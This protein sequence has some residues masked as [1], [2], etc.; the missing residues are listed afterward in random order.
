MTAQVEAPPDAASTGELA[1]TA[2]ATATSIRGSSVMLVGRVAAMG[3]NFAAQ[4]LVVRHLSKA[5][6]GAFAWAL[7]SV[8]LLQSVIALGIDRADTRF[9]AH[10]DERDQ[11]ARLRGLLVIE[12]ST[13]VMIGLAALGAA[14]T[15]QAHLTG[16]VAP[17][18]LAAALLLVLLV[19]A[20]L[21]ALDALVV[22]LFAVFAS[23][24]SVFVRRYVLEPGLRLLVVV[25]VV[26][27]DGTTRA[28]AWGYVLAGAVGLGIYLVLLVRLL[29]R[30]GLAG[31]FK[32]A[33]R[34]LPL[35]EVFTFSL[36]LLLSNLVA[37]ATTEL[38]VVVLGRYGGATE[39]GALRAVQPLAALN[40]V[41]M[42]SFMTLF[43]PAAARAIARGDLAAVRDLYWR[44]AG[45][46]TVLTA[47]VLLL[48][49]VFAR[50]VIDVTLG[51][52]YG[53]SAPYLASLSL[54]YFVNAALGFNG[55]TVQMLG[56][57][58]FVLVTNLAVLAVMVGFDL[59]LIPRFGAGGAAVAVLAT[60]LVHNLA[61]QAGLTGAVGV[62]HRGHG[63]TVAGVMAV[64]LVLG[65]IEA[66][67]RVPLAVAVALTAIAEAPLLWNNRRFLQVAETFPEAARIPVLG[68]SL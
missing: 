56:R 49:T 37:V 40:L 64:V 8:L 22:N 39:V 20:P 4:V 30:T 62:W 15:M 33:P 34:E 12:A 24:W 53:D 7:S 16:T 9:F 5:D 25:G 54:G 31:R 46:I 52:R 13:V 35:R 44:T 50:P 10:Y 45:W 26:L 32:A 42:F 65:A 60:L 58:R 68:R 55:I 3:V 38:A 67:A 36:P 63:R 23:P 59:L 28:L 11:P 17:N 18:G 66:L 41:V 27:S 21:Q 47:P 6:Y 1:A 14:L 48:T 57:L 61:K 19:L 2:T 51:A 29:D 43:A